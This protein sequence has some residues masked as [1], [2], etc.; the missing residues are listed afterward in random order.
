M[1]FAH[2][3]VNAIKDQDMTVAA[4]GLSAGELSG[5]VDTNCFMLNAVL[6]G[7]LYGGVPGNR[8]TAFAGDPATGKTFFAIATVK[9]FL[10][11]NPEG[12]VIYYDTESA[13]NKSMFEERGI[14]PK[15]VIIAEPETIEDFKTKAMKMLSAYKAKK[16]AGDA[17]PM[18]MVL[19]SLGMLSTEK[20]MEDS[21][22]GKNVRDMTKS[23]MLKAAF[24]V[25]TLRC[26]KVDVPLILTNHVYEVIG[27]MYASK[28]MGG[29]GGAKY[30]ASTIAFLS[31]AKD[32]DK[33]NKQVGNIITIT[34]NKS[35]FTKEN[36][37]AK[38]KL[39]FVKGLDKWY[40]MLEFAVEHGIAVK[41]S[42][43]TYAFPANGDVD[44]GSFASKIYAEPEKYFTPAV[45]A[46][47]EAKVGEVFKYGGGDEDEM[48]EEIA[49]A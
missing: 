19:D 16:D 34:M 38:V 21:E 9:S 36:S 15:R 8:V 12:V 48:D 17:P 20:E 25:L 24:R 5:F 22:S 23:Q 35:R 18:M 11:H 7:S 39:D 3:L 45:M 46:E 47:M 14:D 4:D 2:D 33:D 43:K 42:G 10:D 26:A 41:P 30:A 32:R 31:K 44:K 13:V 49:E 6:S 28:E 29:G 37:K 40:G 1:S 27:Q